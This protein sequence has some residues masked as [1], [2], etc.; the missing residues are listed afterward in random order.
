MTFALNKARYGQSNFN[1]VLTDEKVSAMREAW[2][3]KGRGR[4]K[5]DGPSISSLA[6]AHGVSY[7]TVWNALHHYTYWRT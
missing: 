5:H 6:K 3:P 4:K 7:G 2:I 1:A